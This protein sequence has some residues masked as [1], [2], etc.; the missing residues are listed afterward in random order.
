MRTKWEENEIRLDD[1]SA[2]LVLTDRPGE[3]EINEFYRYL[4]NSTDE[5]AESSESEFIKQLNRQ[6]QKV[7]YDHKTFSCRNIA[8]RL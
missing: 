2:V 3:P 7:R 5:E 1:G 4:K 8:W 6:V